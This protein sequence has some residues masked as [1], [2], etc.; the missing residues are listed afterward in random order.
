MTTIEKQE[1]KVE[2]LNWRQEM[3]NFFGP[4][5]TKRTACRKTKNG[6]YQMNTSNN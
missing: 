6:T 4:T 3:R 2:K 5:W 1:L